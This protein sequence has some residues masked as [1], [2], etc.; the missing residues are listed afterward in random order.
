MICDICKEASSE[1]LKEI[2][3][4]F[5]LYINDDKNLNQDD[6]HQKETLANFVKDLEKN[7]ADETIKI[8][9]N[10]HLFPH[11]MNH[12]DITYE[13]FLKEKKYATLEESV[14]S[15]DV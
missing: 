1:N 7:S 10:I 2:L 3:S 9:R 11:L 12:K 13:D 4:S 8:L 6:N 15:I 14:S 5:Q